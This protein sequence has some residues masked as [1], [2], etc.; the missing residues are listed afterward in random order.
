MRSYTPLR[1]PGGKAKLY[2]EIKK[3]IEINF[4]EAPAYVEPFVGGGG[5]AFKLLL[6][7][8]VSE[9]YINDLDDAIYSFWYSIF[10]YNDEFI[11]LIRN[12]EINMINWGIQKNIYENPDGHTTLEKGFATFFLN[13][14]NRSGIMKAGPIGGKKQNGNYLMDCRFNKENLIYIIERIYEYRDRVHIYSEDAKEFITHIDEELINAFIYLDPPY[15]DKGPVLYKNSFVNDDHK[16]LRD[17]IQTL[18]NK[19]FI[20]YDD[21]EYVEELYQDY[22]QSR[23]DL[24]YSVAT[25]RTGTEIS[26]YG[27]ELITI[28]NL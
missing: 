20:T 11:R 5:L 6:N 2:P 23:F 18:R 15:V 27:P 28:D 3:L 10:N 12:T 16:D 14:T 22:Y 19:W 7:E 17:S 21:H 8:V 25:N 4:D 9:I 13:R 26:I 24:N 1:Y